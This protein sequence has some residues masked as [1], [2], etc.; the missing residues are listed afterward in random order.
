[1]RWML[2]PRIAFRRG[3]GPVLHGPTSRRRGLE[4]LGRGEEEVYTSA[5]CRPLKV[6]DIVGSEV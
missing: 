4:V 6:P 1:M 5:S 3:R 2:K